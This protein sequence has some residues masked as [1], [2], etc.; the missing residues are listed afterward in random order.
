VKFYRVE[1]EDITAIA[2]QT[3]YWRPQPDARLRT[4]FGQVYAE[5][6]T[7]RGSYL[8][9]AAPARG[10]V[11]APPGMDADEF[12]A[13]VRTNLSDLDVS[14]GPPA[15]DLSSP[16]R[17]RMRDYM[18]KMNTGV[19]VGAIVRLLES[20]NLGVHRGTVSRWM[21]EDAEA[22]LVE[23]AGKFGAYRWRGGL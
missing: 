5:R 19:S 6:W 1:P 13:I 10:P 12:E 22:G 18:R 20:E 4:A 2:K 7:V 3:G 9:P 16:A 14:A 11:V 23:P 17:K 8:V 15:D 21:K